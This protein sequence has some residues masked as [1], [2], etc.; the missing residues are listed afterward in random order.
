[1]AVAAVVLVFARFLQHQN[2]HAIADFQGRFDR[3]GQSDANAFLEDQPIHH[4]GDVMLFILV[5]MRNVFDVINLAVDADA[6]K[7]FALDADKYLAVLA[8]LAA[9]QRGADLDFGAFRAAQDEST[10]WVVC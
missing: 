8:F 4:R 10:I 2:N 1:M 5:Q 9:N 6:H 7:A 3:V